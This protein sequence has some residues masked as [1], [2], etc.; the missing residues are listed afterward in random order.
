MEELF[1][2]GG[3]VKLNPNPLFDK[4]SDIN[5]PP[6]KVTNPPAGGTT[7]TLYCMFEGD[8]LHLTLV[9]GTAL[10]QVCDMHIKRRVNFMRK[11]SLLGYLR[12]R[13]PILAANP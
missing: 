7:E 11:T 1:E 3:P 4:K 10:A 2:L 5:S 8:E 13:Q 6:P 12:G 9:N